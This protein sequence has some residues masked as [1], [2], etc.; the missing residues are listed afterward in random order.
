MELKLKPKENIAI[1]LDEEHI[2]GTFGIELPI[3]KFIEQNTTVYNVRKHDQTK[4]EITAPTY[5]LKII[6]KW[7]LDNILSKH[8]LK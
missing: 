4:R 6:Q 5:H 1:F 7:I 3:E 2:I 8:K